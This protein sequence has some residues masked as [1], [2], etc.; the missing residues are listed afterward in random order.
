MRGGGERV[1]VIKHNQNFFYCGII[2]FTLL[3]SVLSVWTYPKTIL[4]IYLTFKVYILKKAIKK[5]LFN[6]SISSAAVCFYNNFMALEYFT[7]FFGNKT[8]LLSIPSTII[9]MLYAKNIVR[10]LGL[11]CC[12][13]INISHPEAMFVFKYIS[14]SL[15]RCKNQTPK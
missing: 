15:K 12:M 13:F 5:F 8:S 7:S 10:K 2:K 4:W 11:F 14:T 9:S 3:L 6:I 1:D